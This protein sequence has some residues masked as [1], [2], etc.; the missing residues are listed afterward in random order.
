MSLRLALFGCTAAASAYAVGRP[1]AVSSSSI[2][3]APVPTSTCNAGC[4]P[5]HLKLKHG[6]AGCCSKGHESLKC[7]RPAHFECGSAPPT[8]PPT[9]PPP[10]PPPGTKIWEFKTNGQEGSSAA[11]S[12]DGNVVFAGGYSGADSS[13]NS[14][15]YALNAADGSTLWSTEIE[16]YGALLPTPTL[17]GTLAVDIARKQH[18]QQDSSV[19]AVRR[20]GGYKGA[21]QY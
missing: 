9:P 2:L 8:P 4:I 16:Q 5:E 17:D 19:A 10:P 1:H 21:T 11:I 20:S 14:Y 12:S 13:V 6:K 7:P 3:Y 15:I 18:P